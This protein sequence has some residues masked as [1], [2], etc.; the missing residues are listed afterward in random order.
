MLTLQLKQKQRN[1]KTKLVQVSY[2]PRKRILEPHQLV[3]GGD[4]YLSLN[5]ST[6]MLS[7][8]ILSSTKLRSHSDIAYA[9]TRGKSSLRINREV[10]H[11]NVYYSE[12]TR[13]YSFWYFSLVDGQFLTETGYTSPSRARQALSKIICSEK[14]ELKYLQQSEEEIY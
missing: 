9:N 1:H 8:V 14:K 4:I 12:S 10:R 7:C 2:K 5:N 11:E 3:I 13:T 6:E